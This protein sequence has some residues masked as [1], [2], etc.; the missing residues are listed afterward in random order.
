MTD[1]GA[2][3]AA[4]SL[5]F[6]VVAPGVVAG[7]IPWLLTGWDA[8][9]GWP[10]PLRLAGAALVCAGIAALLEAFARFV[11]EGLGTPAPVAP[12]RHLV[13]GGLYRFVR[14]PMYLAVGAIIVGQALFLGRTIL[15]AY[16]AV[17]FLAVAAFVR[18]YEEPTLARRYGVEYESY[19]R[20]VP[21]WRP[22]STPWR[23]G[24]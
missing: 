5:V 17:F 10:W 9:G 12:T 11:V 2:R 7:L 21:A 8:R 22:R 1:S 16:A 19:R 24:R 4:G 14:N 20:A 18:W 3:E 15:L 6:L 23:R 13:V